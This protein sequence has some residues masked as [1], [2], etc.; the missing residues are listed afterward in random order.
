MPAG[1]CRRA[2]AFQIFTGL[3]VT[4]ANCE[5]RRPGDGGI[6]IYGGIATIENCDFGTSVVQDA[7]VS[8][9]LARV[10]S[11]ANSGTATR[12]GLYAIRGGDIRKNG[13]QPSGS[14]ANELTASG[15]SIA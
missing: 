12:Y 7:I 9:D 6:D 11:E 15:G 10:L 1:V 3:G 4:V 13:A 14:T 5:P 8:R 2:R